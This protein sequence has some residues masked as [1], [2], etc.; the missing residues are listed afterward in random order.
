[1]TISKEIE[2]AKKRA[3]LLSEGD[4]LDLYENEEEPEIN[5]Y[6]A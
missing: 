4:D 3:D 5:Q 1:M 6:K 2:E